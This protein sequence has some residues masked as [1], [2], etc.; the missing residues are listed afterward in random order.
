MCLSVPPEIT[1]TTTEEPSGT[2]VTQCQNCDSAVELACPFSHEIRLR[3]AFYGRESVFVCSDF[4][5]TTESCRV[6]I[7]PSWLDQCEGQ[8]TCSVL[9]ACHS[10]HG[11]PV[12]RPGGL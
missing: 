4:Y 12:R 1:T 8:Q 7:A 3:E 10:D 5:A 11:D 6:D 9:K 2:V